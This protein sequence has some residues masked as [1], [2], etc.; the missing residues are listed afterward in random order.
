MLKQ[1]VEKTSERHFNDSILILMG[2]PC[3][4][5]FKNKFGDES[6]WK[7]AYNNTL[8]RLSTL[9]DTQMEDLA[10]IEEYYKIKVN[11]KVTKAK[12]TWKKIKFY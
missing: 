7:R 6:G 12:Q 2:I 11:Y 8:T 1:I 10:R 4:V 9:N 5:E 3:A